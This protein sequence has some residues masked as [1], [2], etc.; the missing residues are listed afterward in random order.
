M[1]HLLLVLIL[2][3]T[4][5]PLPIANGGRCLDSGKWIPM[6]L[7]LPADYTSDVVRT[8]K[9]VTTVDNLG[10]RI[11]GFIYTREDGKTYFGARSN[12]NMT[13][14]MYPVLDEFLKVTAPKGLTQPERDERQLYRNDNGAAQYRVEL[15][16][17]L[18]DS[19]NLQLEPC[20]AWP[21]DVP[22]PG[23]PMK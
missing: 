8:D 1:A 17:H 23:Q 20:L 5:T 14:A 6:N 4:P 3:G 19:L 10:G 18:L 15:N 7:G 22:L 21:K 11:L 13:P 16:A 2:A 12:A 9:L